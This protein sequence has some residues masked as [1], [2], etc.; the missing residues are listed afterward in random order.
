MTAETIDHTTLSKLAE[1]GAVRSAHVVGQA[2]G[3]GIL[4][5]Y[6]MTERALAAQRS[7]QVRIFRKFETLV[8]YLKGV[9]IARFDVDT[10]NYDPASLATARTRPDSAAK[11]KIAH[12]AAAYD[13][14]FREQVQASIDDPRPSISDNEARLMFAARKA[15][16]RQSTQ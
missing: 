8:N 7:H 10:A 5:K 12:E 15:A 1:A 13:V 14:W 6:G 9:G 3:W 16:L 11:L 4:V 2:G